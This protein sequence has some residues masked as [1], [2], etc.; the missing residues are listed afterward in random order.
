[1]VRGLNDFFS[2]TYGT[3]EGD[4][5]GIMTAKQ[6]AE[7]WGI[8]SRRV[9]EIIRKGRITGA[10]KAGATW[11]MPDDTPKPPD[12]RP[13]RKGKDRNYKVLS[14]PGGETKNKDSI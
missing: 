14:P 12:L 1:M 8:S 3:K 6:A 7:K 10:E 4:F 11:I 2:N 5:L 13:L 9:N